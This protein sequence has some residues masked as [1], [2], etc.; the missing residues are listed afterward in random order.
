MQHST[1]QQPHVER[2]NGELF[3][4]QVS[5]KTLAGTYG[6][7]AYVYSRAALEDAWRRY[8]VA[9]GA[10]RHRIHYA[11]KANAN[12]AV[13]NTLA[14]LGSGFD[15]VSG[16]ELARVLAAQ[17]NAADVVFSGVGKSADE[18]RAALAAGVGV[19]NVESPAELERLDAVARSMGG[20]ASIALRVN[21]DVDAGTHPYISTGL[22]ENKFGVPMAEAL[23]LY[24]HAARMPGLRVTGVACHIGSQLT[25]LSPFRDALS[26]VM[27]LVTQ[28]E[29]DGISLDHIDAGGGLGIQYRDEQPPRTED[30][31]AALCAAIPARYEICIEPGR[32]ICGPAG[33]LLSRVEYLKTT[34]ARH[35]AILDVA[36][37]EL[38]R[39]ALYEAWHEVVPVESPGPTV[40]PRTYDL[41]GPVCES[42][43][44]LATGRELALTEGALVAI[45]SAGAYGHVMASNYNARPRPPELL[46]D[47]A[48][49]HVARPRETVAELFA[50]ERLLP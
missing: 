17:G 4:E 23:A 44:F 20:R 45:L 13:L 6:T 18:M 43:D 9:F 5:L 26:R 12:L 27:A 38:I 24:R 47:G 1:M 28:L 3:V 37:T 30:Y 22:N 32:S 31:V 16:G 11:V 8:D 21:P 19:F 10:R 42:A 25:D 50:T 15:I 39:P 33:V 14:R 34:P 46:V 2:R 49:V 29:A 40:P 36:M 35:F 48:V 41:V 7:P